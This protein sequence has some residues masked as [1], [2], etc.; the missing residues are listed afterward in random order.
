MSISHALRH[1][2]AHQVVHRLIGE[3]GYL[4]VEQRNIDMLSAASAIATSQC[5]ENRDCRIQAGED[6]GHRNADL[7]GAA[8]G[9]FIGLAGD[10]H[11][12]ARALNHEVVAWLVAIGSGLAKAG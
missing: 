1:L 3:H 9:T 7:Y 5:A 8:A 2:P 6:I 11:Q 12:A 10:T 4:R